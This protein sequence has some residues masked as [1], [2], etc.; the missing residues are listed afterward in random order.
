MG[1]VYHG[2]VDVSRGITLKIEWM[3]GWV[4]GVGLIMWIMDAGVV[5]RFR[6]KL[7]VSLAC[8]SDF[9]RNTHCSHGC[10][11]PGTI[12]CGPDVQARHRK[13]AIALKIPFMSSCAIVGIKEA[14]GATK[15]RSVEKARCI[16]TR[17]PALLHRLEVAQSPLFDFA[18]LDDIDVVALKAGPR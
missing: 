16:V 18:I 15:E 7:R 9:R 8:Q 17:S 4:W 13:T 2:C 11:T 10:L 14:S 5:Y 6:W 12:V 3:F 1:V